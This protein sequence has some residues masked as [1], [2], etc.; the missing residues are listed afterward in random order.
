M[1]EH[2]DQFPLQAANIPSGRDDPANR[3]IAWRPSPHYLDRSRLR[4]FM[5]AQGIADF[6][7]LLNRSAQE[8]EWFWDAAVKDLDFQF[9]TPYEKIMDAS[10]GWEWTTWF[11][12]AKYN[13]VHDALDKRATGPDSDRLAIIFE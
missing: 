5:Q 1:T 10:K 3:D 4:A 2:T 6:D 8:P 7:E 13:Y 12:G 11:T 9:Y